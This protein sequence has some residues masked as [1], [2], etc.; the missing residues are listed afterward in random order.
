ME[1]KSPTDGVRFRS[2]SLTMTSKRHRGV[3]LAH[4]VGKRAGTDVVV[5]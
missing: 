1:K 4:D 2:L 3:A 5:R